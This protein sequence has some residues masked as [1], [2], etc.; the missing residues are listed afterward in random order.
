MS[1]VDET[2]IVVPTFLSPYSEHKAASYEG[3]LSVSRL[4]SSSQ[5]FRYT[6]S[7]RNRLLTLVYIWDENRFMDF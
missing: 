3:Q 5:R 2:L 6:S 4:P 1:T 7:T